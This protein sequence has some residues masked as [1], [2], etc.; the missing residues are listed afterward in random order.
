MRRKWGVHRSQV[1]TFLSNWSVQI[2]ISKYEESVELL[3][4]AKIGAP[5]CSRRKSQF[6]ALGYN[7]HC[8]ETSRCL[9]EEKFPGNQTI[10][11]KP[12][13]FALIVCWSGCMSV[14]P[15]WD[16]ASQQFLQALVE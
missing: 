7:K 6:I 10:G 11:R 16:V 13:C 8:S 12:V 15:V 3:P 2:T 14:S 5:C 9:E 1:R 4:R